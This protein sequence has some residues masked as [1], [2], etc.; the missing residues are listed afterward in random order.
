MRLMKASMVNNGLN[1]G[2]FKD[3]RSLVC[4]CKNCENQEQHK[5]IE[6]PIYGIGRC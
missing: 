1:I 3:I 2:S 6:H 4:I 5:Y